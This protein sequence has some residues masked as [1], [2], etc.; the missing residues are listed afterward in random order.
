MHAYE[1]IEKLLK[2]RFEKLLHTKVEIQFTGDVRI[3]QDCAGNWYVRGDLVDVRLEDN[4]LLI[5]GHADID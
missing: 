1:L 4:R 2:V 3:T 5:L